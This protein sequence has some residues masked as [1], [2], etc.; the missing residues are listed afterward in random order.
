MPAQNSVQLGETTYLVPQFRLGK[1]L[2]MMELISDLLEKVDLSS[3]FGAASQ[4]QAS[5]LVELSD[6]LPALVRSARPILL[7]MMA[8]ALI[9]DRRLAEIDEQDE[10]YQEELNS[11]VRVL[12]VEADMEKTFE[13]LV[14]AVDGMGIDAIRKNFPKVLQRLRNG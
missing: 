13:I 11:I 6:K 3:I 12:K 10:S 14:L 5:L 8:L 2:R 7:K 1:T 4:G 9:P